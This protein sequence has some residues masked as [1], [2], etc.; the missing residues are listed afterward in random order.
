MI[1]LAIAH[2]VRPQQ[3]MQVG[4]GGE[5]GKKNIWSDDMWEDFN[6]ASQADRDIMIRMWGEPSR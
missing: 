4:H 5:K 3:T 2:Y 6:K 1:S